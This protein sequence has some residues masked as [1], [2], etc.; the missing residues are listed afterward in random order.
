LISF[1][2]ST[3]IFC[4]AIPEKESLIAGNWNCLTSVAARLW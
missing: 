2:T 4:L 3:E 1:F